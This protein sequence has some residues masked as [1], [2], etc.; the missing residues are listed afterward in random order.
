M[1][2]NRI[3][4]IEFESFNGLLSLE[5]LDLSGNLI[6]HFDDDSLKDLGNIK[7]FFFFKFYYRNKSGYV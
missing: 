7:E 5:R 2:F 3:E 1:I 6:T 4:K